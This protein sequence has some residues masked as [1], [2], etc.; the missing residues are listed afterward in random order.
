MRI[1]IDIHIYVFF[2]FY[3][4]T[5]FDFV[6]RFVQIVTVHIC[7]VGKR[8]NKHKTPAQDRGHHDGSCRPADSC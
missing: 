8:F 5:C 6:L 4:I 7:D 3:V 1:Y 2:H